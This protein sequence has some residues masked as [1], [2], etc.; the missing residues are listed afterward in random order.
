MP[1]ERLSIRRDL[2]EI[3]KDRYHQ[4]STLI[5]SQLPVKAWHDSIGDAT[6]GDAIEVNKYIIRQFVLIQ[7][8]DAGQDHE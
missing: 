4:S 2:L 5:T 8:T 1:T 3:I 6:L 7:G